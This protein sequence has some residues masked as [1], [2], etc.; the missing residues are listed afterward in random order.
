MAE[1][2]SDMTRGGEG[3][4]RIYCLVGISMQYIDLVFPHISTKQPTKI[5][6][7]GTPFT[8]KPTLTA[9]P[10]PLVLLKT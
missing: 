4:K 3:K 7:L 5:S 8:N 2:I 10:L 9:I 1:G 6:L